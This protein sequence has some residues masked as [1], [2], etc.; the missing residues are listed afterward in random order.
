MVW[1]N[2]TEP[3]QS[4][5]GWRRLLFGVDSC[6]CS[7]AK[8]NCHGFIS[9]PLSKNKSQQNHQERCHEGLDEP[10]RDILGHGAF[11][12][13]VKQMKKLLLFLSFVCCRLLSLLLF[14][15]IV[16]RVRVSF[17]SMHPPNKCILPLVRSPSEVATKLCTHPV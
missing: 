10:R 12:S 11:S 13:N 8:Q 16:C 5:G 15:V 7:E 6:G 3:L 2:T 17:P 9:N 4:I 14:A 1:Q